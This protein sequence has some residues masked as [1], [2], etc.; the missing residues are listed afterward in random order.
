MKFNE[1]YENLNPEIKEYFKIIS[2]HFP[3][4]LIPFI[5][6]KTLMRLKDVSYF[7]VLLMLVQKSII[8]NM[9]FLDWIILF[10]VHYMYGILLIM[11]F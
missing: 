5:E 11:I 3:K 2:S 8:L 7:A 1:Y 9:I 10:L 6:S 4:F